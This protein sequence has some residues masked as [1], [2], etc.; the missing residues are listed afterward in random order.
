LFSEGKYP[1]WF[2]SGKVETEEEEDEESIDDLLLLLLLLLL[3]ILDLLLV[4]QLPLL[5]E[6]MSTEELLPPFLHDVIDDRRRV[7]RLDEE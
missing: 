3:E 2:C 1:F 5:L 6:G 4:V 7:L